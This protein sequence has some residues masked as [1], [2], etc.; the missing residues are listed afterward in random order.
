MYILSGNVALENS[1]ILAN[2]VVVVSLVQP[3]FN[4]LDL[5]MRNNFAGVYHTLG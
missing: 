5:K 4:S 2:D 1:K 3:L